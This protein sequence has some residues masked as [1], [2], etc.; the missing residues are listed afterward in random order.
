ML[1]ACPIW[2]VRECGQG[3]VAEIPE[4]SQAHYHCP[5]AGR[6]DPL[7]RVQEYE[8]LPARQSGVGTRSNELF[9]FRGA[10]TCD[11]KMAEVRLQCP[12][13]ASNAFAQAICVWTPIGVANIDIQGVRMRRPERSAQAPRRS[14]FLLSPTCLR[15]SGLR[16]GYHPYRVATAACVGQP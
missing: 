7:P 3:L 15:G 8:L 12:V 16:L 14:C 10:I 6:P 9:R 2:R 13:K 11:S 1:F 5:R 4:A